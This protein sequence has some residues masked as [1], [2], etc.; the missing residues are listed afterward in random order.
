MALLDPSRLTSI[1]VVIQSHGLKGELRVR[2]LTDAP[3]YYERR[4]PPMILGTARGMRPLTILEVRRSGADWV[5]LIEGVASREAADALR[6]A[7]I[8][9][10]AAHLKPLEEGEVF[11]DDLLGSRVLTVAGE[12]LGEVTGLLDIG[13][14]EVLEVAGPRGEV[15]VPLIPSIVISMDTAAREIRV[16]PPPGLLELNATAPDDTEGVEE[17]GADGAL[18]A[19]DEKRDAG[20]RAGKE[21]RRPPARRRS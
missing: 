17:S 7:E 20:R 21:K 3:E 19:H 15:L 13:P 4:R 12:L 1:G 16:D 5:L 18:T 6:G 9:L 8:L 11:S 14:N 2:L 10:D